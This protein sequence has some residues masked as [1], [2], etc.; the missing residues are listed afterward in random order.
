MEKTIPCENVG[1]H[2]YAKTKK[3]SVIK[4]IFAFLDSYPIAGAEFM[5]RTK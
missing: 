4:I 1:P 5:S 3:R 2:H